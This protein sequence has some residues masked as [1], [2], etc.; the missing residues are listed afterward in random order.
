MAFASF[1]E[2][3]PPLPVGS[4]ILDCSLLQFHKRRLF[5]ALHCLVDVGD[6]GQVMLVM[7]EFHCRF[8]DG[9]FQGIIGIRQI[10]QIIRL[11][12]LQ[13]QHTC[14]ST[15]KAR[16]Q[17]APGSICWAHKAPLQAA[18]QHAAHH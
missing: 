18:D 9:R 1:S 5:L 8:V 14:Q 12:R 15:G 10:R 13:T 6:I 17:R 11:S 3:F 16:C 7:V 2:G 4:T